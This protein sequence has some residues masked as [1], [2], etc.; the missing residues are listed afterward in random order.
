MRTSYSEALSRELG[1]KRKAM[2]GEFLQRWFLLGGFISS[3]TYKR[4]MWSAN[5]DLSRSPAAYHLTL[6]KGLPE[7]GANNRLIMAGHEWMLRQWF[8]KPLKRRDIELAIDWYTTKSAVPLFPV[9]IFDDLLRTQSGQN[10]YLPIDI[11]G[12]PGGQTF[13][14]GVPALVFTGVGGIVSFLEPQMCRYYGPVIHATKGRLMHEAAGDRSA[15]FGYRADPN[16]PMTMAKLLAIYIGN[17]GSRILTS[18]DIAEFMFPWLF[19]TIGTIGH[20]FMCALQDF[21][22]GLDQAEREAMELFVT[23]HGNGSLL[24]DLVDAETVGLENAIRVFKNHIE[25]RALGIRVDSGDIAAQC[26]QIY[27]RMKAEGIEGRTIVFEDEV[28]PDKVREVF[29]YFLEHTGVEPTMLF[30]GAGGYY[31]RAFHRDTVS[32]AFKRSSTNGHPNTKFS[33]SPGKESVPGIIRVYGRG[34]CMVVADESENIDGI[35]LYV[36]LVR[37]GRIVYSEDMD[38]QR[39]A[40]RAEETWSQY[41]HYEFSPLI[42]EWMTKFRQMRAEAQERVRALQRAA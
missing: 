10:I 9:E 18:A 38:F 11:D 19:K 12:F 8:L 20:E 2:I 13:L 34:D 14:A 30:P 36:P 37:K 15:E 4:T 35:P 7:T 41:T 27:L 32:A 16:E 3:D 22:K 31:Y 25:V 33:N 26:V 24:C 21:L 39:Q 40:R 6:R 28:T 29:A 42:S 17:G 1:A 5:Y 23:A